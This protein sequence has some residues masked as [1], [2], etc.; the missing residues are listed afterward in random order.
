M[1]RFLVGVRSQFLD[2]EVDAQS[3]A[4][5]QFDPAVLHPQRLRRNIPAQ[6]RKIHEIF[7]DAEIRDDC[8]DM[9]GRI[10]VIPPMTQISGLRISAARLA[11][12]SKNASLV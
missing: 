2:I 1:R 6:I 11:R 3:G 12:Q 4:G 8:R 5:R 10:A 7:G 9:D